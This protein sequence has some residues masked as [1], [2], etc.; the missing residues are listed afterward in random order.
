MLYLLLVAG[1]VAVTVGVALLLGASTAVAL[2]VG[3][4]TTVAITSITAGAS[5]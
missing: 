5:S 2:I 4:L 1:L 3:G